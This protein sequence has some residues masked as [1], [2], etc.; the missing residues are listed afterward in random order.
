MRNRKFIDDWHLLAVALFI[1]LLVYIL[2]NQT[3]KGTP[4][5][6]QPII[7]AQDSAFFNQL[8]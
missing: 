8:R 3:V 7:T 4:Q 2:N 6:E 1:T 5:A